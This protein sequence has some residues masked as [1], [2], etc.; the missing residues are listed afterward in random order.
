MLKSFP[1][2]VDAEL[3]HRGYSLHTVTAE[4]WTADYRFVADVSN[5]E[6]EV[7]TLGT[8]VVEAG[9]NIVTKAS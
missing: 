1:H 7:T 6:S 5:A 3:T 2:L 4:R 9:T 8:Y